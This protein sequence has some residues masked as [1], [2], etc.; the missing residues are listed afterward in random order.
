MCGG[1]LVQTLEV[2]GLNGWDRIRME[3][4]QRRDSLVVLGSNPITSSEHVQPGVQG[5]MPH[6]SL[7]CNPTLVINLLQTQG[8]VCPA[9]RRVHAIV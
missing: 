9:P 4:H 6:D 3:A 7:A 1:D 2:Y 5:H 8:E